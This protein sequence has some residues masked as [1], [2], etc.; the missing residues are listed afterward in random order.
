MFH[1]FVESGRFRPCRVGRVLIEPGA[2]PYFFEVVL[3]PEALWEVGVLAKLASAFT[4]SGAPLLGVKM[5]AARS[6]ERLRVLFA[7][8]LKGREGEAAKLVDRLKRVPG[9][10][11]V[12]Y[13]PPLFDG[14]AVDAWSH[15]LLLDDERAAILPYAFTTGMLKRGWEEYGTG[16][17]AILYHVAL[18]GAVEE[19]RGYL[20]RFGRDESVKLIEERFR[21]LGYGVLK[22]VRLTEREL[23]ARVYD[24]V[25]C[26]AF[27]GA[28]EPRGALTRGIVAGIAAAVWNAPPESVAAEEVKCLAKGDSYCE[29]R[30]RRR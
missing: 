14:V 19:C 15:P 6:G 22:I 13:A 5:S 1:P 20:E 10:E 16:F 29:F 26:G 28:G 11:Q 21:L 27:R 7:A 9:V 24:S 2:K 23:V 25:E 4:E 3:K 17:A 18:A 8:D 12:E 30:V